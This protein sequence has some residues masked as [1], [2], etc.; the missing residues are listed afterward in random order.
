M[1]KYA[2]LQTKATEAASQMNRYREDPGL[3]KVGEHIQW[4]CPV[5]IFHGW[6]LVYYEAAR[7][8]DQ[9]KS[10]SLPRKKTISVARH[11]SY[12]RAPV[13]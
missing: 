6:E 11:H 7:Q 2:L 8:G 12:S 1:R 10:A 4:I 5:L 13:L 3:K 9:T